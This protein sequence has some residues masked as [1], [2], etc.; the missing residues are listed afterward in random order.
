LVVASA[1]IVIALTG[2]SFVDASTVLEGS[3]G[4][5]V[6]RVQDS[7]SA[8]DN[9][10]RNVRDRNDDTLTPLDQSNNPEDLQV[11]RAIRKAVMANEALSTTAQNIKIITANGKVT[12]R[13]PVS[14][15]IERDTI[16]YKA[17]ELANG[18]PVINQLE[19]LTR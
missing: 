8:P 13:G 17:R 1:V 7:R 15:A 9:T 14:N 16:V 10:G 3:A 4:V 2:S 5:K 11:T 18:R 6:Y 12:L 19:V